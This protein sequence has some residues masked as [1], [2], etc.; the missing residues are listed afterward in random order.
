MEQADVKFHFVPVLNKT[1]TG[2]CASINNDNENSSSDTRTDAGGLPLR[3][4][5]HIYPE[6]CDHISIVHAGYMECLGIRMC[7][8]N[9]NIDLLSVVLEQSIHYIQAFKYPTQ[10][11][12]LNYRKV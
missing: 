9:V 6:Y 8:I 1:Q 4:S 5:Q 3:D 7:D 12:E 10:Y 2:N 11:D